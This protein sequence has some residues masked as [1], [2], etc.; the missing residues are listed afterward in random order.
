MTPH[1]GLDEELKQALR[2]EEAPPGFTE[3]VLAGVRRQQA[4]EPWWRGWMRVD[5][6][7][8]R[9]ATTLVLVIAVVVGAWEYRRHEQE[10]REG[11]AARR[12]VLLALRIA[13][14]KLQYAQGKVNEAGRQ[15]GVVE[16]KAVP[17]NA[18]PGNKER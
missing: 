4:M 11:E 17:G 5:A 13:S 10:H 1:D 12:Q 15:D 7:A 9:Y 8:L 14:R 3:R 2:R 16:R 6:L 18:V